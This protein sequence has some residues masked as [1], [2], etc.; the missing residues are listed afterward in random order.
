M[1]RKGYRHLPIVDEKGDLQGVVS[2]RDII[3][4]L[5]EFFPMEIYNLPPST[6]QEQDQVFDTREGG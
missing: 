4:Y 3:G 1:T 2:A 5:A 6:T